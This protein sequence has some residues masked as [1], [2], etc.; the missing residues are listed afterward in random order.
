VIVGQFTVSI[1]F[2]F[3]TLIIS[4]QVHYMRTKSLGYDRHQV[5]SIPIFDKELFESR[6]AFKAELSRHPDILS[7]SA[8]SFSPGGTI[9]HQSYRYEGMEE[10]SN[11]MIRWIAV[12]DDFI[13]TLNI[14][15][16]SGRKFSPEF[17]TDAGGAYILNETA[18]RSMG[19]SDALGRKISIVEEAPVV[20]VIRDFHFRS[21][22]H[23]IEPLALYIWPP[24]YENY[25]VRYVPGRLPAVLAHI[26][27]VWDRFS[28]AQ[29]FTFA[30]LDG[31]YDNLYRGEQRLGRIFWSVTAISLF[32][33]CL[34]LLGLASFFTERRTREIGIRK[35][36]GASACGVAFMVARDFS[37]WVLAANLIALPAAYVITREWLS[38]F[39]YRITPGVP[40]FVIAGAS[41]LVLA[42]FTVSFQAVKAA[43]TDPA[44]TIRHE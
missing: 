33:A 27:R 42:L 3:V 22:H 6:D 4:R 13:D 28:I 35:V 32:I 11:P 25:L 39:P 40:A 44:A 31:A 8:S 26:R 36:M 19:W 17:P 41:A 2:I 1:L 21:L 34:G 16:V 9:W 12:D 24:G 5:L 23:S 43:R 29:A 14:A 37:R 7:V 10:E 18:V 38:N 30:F 20:G 15:M